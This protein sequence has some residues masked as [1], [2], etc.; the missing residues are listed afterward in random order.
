M[1]SYLAFS[2]FEDATKLSIDAFIRS[3]R[4][5][6][7]QRSGNAAVTFGDIAVVPD[8]AHR[9]RVRQIAQG[10]YRACLEYMDRSFFNRPFNV[11]F[12]SHTTRDLARQ[13]S[14]LANLSIGQDANGL[15]S[16]GDVARRHSSRRG[17]TVADANVLGGDYGAQ[18]VSTAIDFINIGIAFP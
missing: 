1:G 11:L 12:T 7:S 16:R 2:N 8:S 9:F 17:H 13:C 14:N 5:G 3:K 6:K 4:K 10:G 15:L 18:N